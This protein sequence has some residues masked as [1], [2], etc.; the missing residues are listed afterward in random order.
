LPKLDPTAPKG[1]VFK[2]LGGLDEFAADLALASTPEGEADA[3]AAQKE[4][5]EEKGAELAAKPAARPRSVKSAPSTESAL[6]V[7]LDDTE[8]YLNVLYWGR[9]GS[10]K[11]SDALSAANLGRVLVINVEGGLKKT[12]LRHRGVNIDNVQIF[13]RPGEPIT[14]EGFDEAIRQ[15][16]SNLMDDPKSWFAV[17]VDSVTEV[18]EAMTGDVTSDRNVKTERAKNITLSAVDSFFTDRS[19]YGTS[20][21]MMRD[22]LRK[23]R[24][25]QCHVILTALERRDVDEDTSKVAYGPAVPPGLQKD[26]LGYVDIVLYCKEADEERDYYRAQTKKAGKFRAK[27]RLDMLPMVVVDPTFERVMAYVDETII[28]AKDP[29]QEILKKEPVK[30]EKPKPETVAQ[31]RA[32]LAQ[33][34]KDAEA[35]E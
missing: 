23:L 34:K 6:F 20:G 24:D 28:E 14:Y 10:G 3:E 25:L 15:V 4:I 29:V 33:E 12:A 31:K 35:S 2:D 17:V 26:V 21:R 19:D 27:D 11:T 30:V 5:F 9:E 1:P 22:I 32:R 16:K 18:S 13:P 7:P 8:E